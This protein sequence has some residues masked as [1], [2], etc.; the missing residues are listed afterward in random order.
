[1]ATNQQY[2]VTY[3]LEN[4]FER[5]GYDAFNTFLRTR[6]RCVP[7]TSPLSSSSL[8][9]LIYDIAGNQVTLQHQTLDDFPTHQTTITVTAQSEELAQRLLEDTKTEAAKILTDLLYQK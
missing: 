5:A 1:M 6:G 2:T 7:D 4:D 9:L 8:G 3:F